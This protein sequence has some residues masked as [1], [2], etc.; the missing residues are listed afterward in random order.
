MELTPS[1]AFGIQGP[2]RDNILVYSDSRAI[3]H[4]VYP[5]GCHIVCFDSESYSTRFFEQPTNYGLVTALAIAPNEK[6]IAA[7]YRATIG[8]GANV[9]VYRTNG[10]R[11]ASL[12]HRSRVTSLC[13]SGDQLIGSAEDSMNIWSWET[14]KLSFSTSITTGNITR[15]SCPPTQG[16]SNLLVSSTGKGHCRLWIANARH[17]LTNSI[18]PSPNT[19]Q[20]YDYR[21]HTW[22]TT[23]GTDQT[24]FLAIVTEPLSKDGNPCSEETKVCIY[25]VTDGTSSSRPRVELD[26]TIQTELRKGIQITTILAF[27]S[28]PGFALGGSKGT[29]ITYDYHHDGGSH[30]NFVNK[31]RLSKESNGTVVSIQNS[32][33]DR[34]LIYSDENI[35]HELDIGE[36]EGERST[37]TDF[38]T[39]AGHSRGIDDMD[40]CME[41]PLIVS[42]GKDKAV[43]IW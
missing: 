1:H 20:K 3:E 29:V 28:S 24:L 22:L 5:V 38:L 37:F 13:F 8:D 10:K 19:E 23:L 25:K 42:C 26:Q 43:K 34:L 17:R 11:V 35:I 30:Q 33:E 2:I 31:K 36:F 7:A 4:V 32:K 41:K 39:N 16:S 14:E 12:V 21:D 6:N 18:I 27:R 9:V 15:V 40:C